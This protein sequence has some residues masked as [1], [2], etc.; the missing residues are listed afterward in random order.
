MHTYSINSEERK[1][2]IGILGILSIS[3]ILILKNYI[4]TSSWIPVPSAFAVFGAFYY[5]FDQ[6]LWKWHWLY[7]L[8]STSNLN[9]TWIML[10]KSSIDNYSTE[11]EGTLTISV[12]PS[13]LRKRISIRANFALSGSVAFL[14]FPV[15]R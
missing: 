4:K 14:F 1:T 13:S 12:P 5:L 7:R 6:I 2:V 8:L 9:G 11:Y 10:M 15:V 3:T